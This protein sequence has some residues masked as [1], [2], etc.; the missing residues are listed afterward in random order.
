MVTEILTFVTFY[1][2]PWF[3]VMDQHQTVSLDYESGA[4]EPKEQKTALTCAGSSR[5]D[6]AWPNVDDICS[7]STSSTTTEN[8]DVRPTVALSAETSPLTEV[9]G[10]TDVSRRVSARC[11]REETEPRDRKLLPYVYVFFSFWCGVITVFVEVLNFAAVSHLFCLTLHKH[12]HNLMHIYTVSY[13]VMDDS[14]IRNRKSW[15]FAR[16]R[17][18]R[19]LDFFRDF[20]SIFSNA[21]CCSTNHRPSVLWHCWLGRVTRKT[22]SEM[23][24][25]VS[26]GTLN[27]TIPVLH[28]WF[29]SIHNCFWRLSLHYST[30][31]LPNVLIVTV[32]LIIQSHV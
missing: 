24:Y 9:A 6:D 18:N 4:S 20:C 14:R 10:S 3:H 27:S 17:K 29:Q 23:T 30:V 22:V 13:V 25:N 12:N 11:K 19:N 31:P 16:N 8:T 28:A 5:M 21:R 1:I 15:F 26:S 7:S 2:V 32:T